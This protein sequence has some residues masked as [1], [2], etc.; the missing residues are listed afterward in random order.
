M[1]IRRTGSHFHFNYQCI[2]R[3]TDSSDNRLTSRDPRVSYR[4]PVGRRGPTWPA[5]SFRNASLHLPEPFFPNGR[6][7]GRR[8]QILITSSSVR[9]RRTV[10]FSCPR[11]VNKS[12]PLCRF[13]SSTK[14]R[15]IMPKT[16]RFYCI[17]FCLM[18]TC[19]SSQR[20]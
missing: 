10:C 9:A 4:R 14:R 20:D 2:S 5:P 15:R 11:L 13:D 17:V 19:T 12:Y 6:W 18:E 7:T 3:C 16:F 1:R 8:L